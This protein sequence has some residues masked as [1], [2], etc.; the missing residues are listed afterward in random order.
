MQHPRPR[1]PE[2]HSP[3]FGLTPKPEFLEPAEQCETSDFFDLSQIVSLNETDTAVGADNDP[4]TWKLGPH[5]LHLLSESKITVFGRSGQIP[6]NF[7]SEGVYM[8]T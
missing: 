4:V 8:E 5:R 3:R 6:K 2:P 7:F 1:M